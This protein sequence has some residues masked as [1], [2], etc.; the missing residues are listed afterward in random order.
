MPDGHELRID[1]HSSRVIGEVWALYAEALKLF[2][3][4]PT[5]IEWDNDVPPLEVLLQEAAHAQTL[6]DRATNVR[7]H[8][9]A[10]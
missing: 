10:A 5:L 3:P 6:L 4:V 8:V 1:D 2:G 7:H 9:D